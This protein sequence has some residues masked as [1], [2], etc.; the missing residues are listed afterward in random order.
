MKVGDWKMIPL[1][2]RRKR[3]KKDDVKVESMV[4][5]QNNRRVLL[6]RVERRHEDG[7]TEVFIIKASAR[8][9]KTDH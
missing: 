6:H 5:I 3:G 7:H 2:E 4:A 8:D 9:L 1:S